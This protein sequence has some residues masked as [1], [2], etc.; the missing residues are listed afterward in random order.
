MLPMTSSAGTLT[1]L[2]I[3]TANVPFTTQTI[4]G[5]SYAFFT[6]ASGRYTAVYS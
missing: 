1:S 3:G 4:K 6:A 5:V 2:K